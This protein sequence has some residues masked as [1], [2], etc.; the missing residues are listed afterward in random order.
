MT[1][2]SSFKNLD[3]NMCPHFTLKQCNTCQH[4]DLT[5]D[6]ELHLK[7]ENLKK[8][9]NLQSIDIHVKTVKNFAH[10]T[11][12][13]FS[14]KNGQLGLFDESKNCWPVPECQILHPDLLEA[15]KQLR[16]YFQNHQ[17]LFDRASFRLRI[18]P[19]SD[20]GLWMDLANTD[21]KKLLDEKHWLTGLASNYK[22]EIGQK[23]KRLLLKP[24][25]GQHKLSEAKL[26]AWF[27]SLGDPLQ[28]HIGSFTQ[29]SW[30]SADLITSTILDH[31]KKSATKTVFEYGCG[32]G[33]YTIPLLK[34]G[35]DVAVFE[36]DFTALHALKATAQAYSKKLTLNPYDLDPYKNV[37]A[38]VNP[39]R[40]GLH[41][42]SQDLINNP[43]VES[44]IYVSC[45]IDSLAADIQVLS[46]YF[47]LAQVT[48]VDQ[49]PRSQHFETICMLRRV[50]K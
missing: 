41:K 5:Y 21:I 33:Q 13:D 42:F 50:T 49:F 12:F 4:W 17:P 37:I 2:K 9:L 36:T 18:S 45:S 6:Q 27:L 16:L 23:R 1:E 40:S 32:I 14:Y 35:F 39:P 25:H 3:S 22:I 11:R 10:R 24:E 46:P 43:A 19:N 44:I 47:E 28:C 34:T 8:K 26:D 31:L 30:E 38:L 20:W 29:P 48:L 15:Y 7:K